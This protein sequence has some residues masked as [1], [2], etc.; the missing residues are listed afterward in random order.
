MNKVK[1]NAQVLSKDTKTV[2]RNAT[3]LSEAV[4]LL[5]VSV[6]SGVSAY[7]EDFK[8]IGY[9]V[10]IVAAVMIGLRGSELFL[11]YLANK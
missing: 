5:V 2:I 1:K 3:K 8:G 11:K 9:K 7:Q 4:A 10:L 6:Y